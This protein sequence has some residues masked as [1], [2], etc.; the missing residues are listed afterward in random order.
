MIENV[1]HAT[2][3][4]PRKSISLDIFV[5]TPKK[6]HLYVLSVGNYT[7]GGM[8]YSE[9]LVGLCTNIVSDVLRRH[10]RSH[11]VQLENL[12]TVSPQGFADGSAMLT[13][14]S[15]ADSFRAF[16]GGSVNHVSPHVS[17]NVNIPS[18]P[19]TNT[20]DFGQPSGSTDRKSVV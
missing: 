6:S 3:H 19:D 10:E 15:A 18:V 9:Q 16:S 5:V 2:R 4:F 8:R 11:S 20:I 7:R 13:P 1:I 17:V 12:A 14:P